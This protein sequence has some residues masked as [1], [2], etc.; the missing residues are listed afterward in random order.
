MDPVNLFDMEAL[1]KQTMPHN[2]WTFVDAASNDEITK[3]R[4][5]D[6]FERILVNARFLTDVTDRDISTTVLGE[7]ID[8][9]VMV[10][11]TGG[12]RQAHP[13]GERATAT[14]AGRAGTLYTLPTSS[15]YSIEEVAEVATGPLWFQ[16]YHQDD[17]VTEILVKRAKQAGYK[18]ICLT[19]DTPVGSP[20]E[21]D[22]RNLYMAQPGL[23]WGS[24]RDRPDLINRR[25]V[26][27]PDLA[28]WAPPDYVGLTW[29]RLDWLRDLTGLPLIVKGIRTVDDAIQ[30]AEYGVDGIVVS[31]HGG[32]QLDGTPSSIET[33][34]PIA[35]A[36]GDRLE[37]YLDSGVRRGLDVLKA[38]CL[39]AR[40]VLVGRPLYWGLAY[41]GADGVEHMLN[42]LK[43][44]FD[45]AL[46]YVGCRTTDELH[47]G[48]V[49]V[50]DTNWWPR[51]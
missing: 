25:N 49:D 39:G 9:P 22:V 23:H 47:P 24:L 7:K 12:Q 29:D 13:E 36:V 10:A 14:G 31:N 15:G 27:V 20:K 19:V 2:M 11:P 4:N 6:S 34:A 16:L 26:G 50:P 35:E 44:E 43:V 3:R 21:R 5:R 48:I 42:I 45:R 41:G 37:I 32:R 51:N 1:A 30:C 17:E 18:A 46:A 28:D 33:L 38:L 8:F 40:A